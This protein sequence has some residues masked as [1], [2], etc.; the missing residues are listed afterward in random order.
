[1][2]A[3][4]NPTQMNS[5]L[6][7]DFDNIFITLED[8]DKAAAEKFATTPDRWLNWLERQLPLDYPGTN[9]TNRRILLRRCY[10]NPNAFSKHRL[11]FINSAC[12]VIDCP[13]LTARGK[14]STDIHMV[15]DMLEALGNGTYFH[16]FIILSGDADFTP[17]LLKLRRYARYSAVLSVGYASTAYRSASDYMINVNAFIESALEVKYQD[18]RLTEIPQTETRADAALLKSMADRLFEAA[19]QPTGLP[20]NDLPA[21]YKRFSEFKQGNHWLGFRSLKNLTE[22]VVEKRSDLVIVENDDAW[23]VAR[24]IYADWLYGGNARSK[25]GQASPSDLR[26]NIKNLV[27]DL[28]HSS[29]GPI[30]LG[31]LAQ[32]IL[33]KFPDQVAGSNWLNAGTFK[34][35]LMQLQ[36]DGLEISSDGP[37]Y[38][39]DPARHALPEQGQAQEDV[40]VEPATQD[41]FTLEY[42]EL[43]PLAEKIHRLT[44]M[45]YLLPEHYG[46]LFREI[47]REVNERGYQMT[48]TSRTVRDRC[49]ERGAPVARSHV[50]FILTGLYFI[51]YRLVGEGNEDP[52]QL[53]E[54]MV[55][56]T[57]QLCQTAQF[58]L[59]S[60]ETQQVR[61]WLLSRITD[62]NGG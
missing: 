39:Y 8:Q 46:L 4:K 11:N 5:A 20:A 45:P 58:I 16:E 57:I 31:V 24:R 18:E 22:A 23:F 51:G 53:G 21:I 56:N 44:D 32:T 54:K 43:A 37:S 3:A 25:A 26:T 61:Q 47:A 38:L 62:E 42:P 60:E 1:M 19:P 6:F 40:V 59:S 34:S 28:V 14:T 52:Q 15:M 17:L 35:L 9:F 7:I 29:P 36:L 2:D 12:E 49:I 41:V 13:P 33:Q 48:R 30:A 55:E 27:Q 50:N 10:L